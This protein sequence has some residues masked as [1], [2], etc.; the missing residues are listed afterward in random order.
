MGGTYSE[1]NELIQL[2]LN[3]RHLYLFRPKVVNSPLAG[4]GQSLFKGRGMDFEEVRAYQA[5]DDI[6]T[7]DWRVTAR[8]SKAHTKIFKEERERPVLILLD[9]S[10]SLFFGSCLNFKSV[11]ACETA[12]LIA[13]ATQSHKDRVG[14]V[15]F[16]NQT[17]TT[18]RPTSSKAATL[19]LLKQAE[20]LNKALTIKTMPSTPP[21][22]YLT[23]ALRH[24]RRIAL[25]GT[26]LFVI[27]DFKDMSNECLP[28]LSRLRRHCHM[29]AI[30]VSDPLETEL[31]PPASYIITNGMHRYTLDSRQRKHRRS[32]REYQ[33]AQLTQL[34]QQ[35]QEYRIPLLQ[36]TTSSDTTE[37][38]LAYFSRRR[39]S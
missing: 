14:G 3:A 33:Q 1:L 16:N 21:G 10:Y 25:P 31:P 4:G 27:S 35:L 30:R 32:F 8:R 13:W 34:Q 20:K 12:A 7:I 2:R 37:Q 22:G 19:H 26:Q 17:L 39:R 24:A 23:N 6:R 5:G 11:T 15:L 38:L 29:I 36:L 28:Q 9:Q 18:L